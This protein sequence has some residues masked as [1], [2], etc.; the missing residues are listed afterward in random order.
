MQKNLNLDQLIEA[1]EEV[2]E[3]Q[4]ILA[5]TG[6]N[7]V[8]EILRFSDNF[9][10]WDHYPNDDV[11]D[12]TTGAQYYY[13]AHPNPK[14]G[15]TEHGH[16]HTFMKNKKSQEQ[17]ILPLTH[18][19]AIS[20]DVYGI[21]QALFTVNHW[22]TGGIWEDASIVESFLE[23]F[24]IDHARPSWVV[25]RWVNSMLKLYQSE[26]ITLIQERD[27]SIKK[28]RKQHPN[29]DVFEMKEYEITSYLPISIDTKLKSLLAMEQDQIS[30]AMNG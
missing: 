8:A 10:E 9:V 27:I 18:I 30:R 7:I 16:F 13:H 14:R 20:M 19:I 21:P 23:N 3:C 29:E 12:Q 6:D 11:I 17:D 26:I 24:L 15:F 4:R 5:N 25:N 2:I 28:F 1:A 22:V